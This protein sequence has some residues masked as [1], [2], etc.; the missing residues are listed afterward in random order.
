MINWCC[1]SILG[2][3]ETIIV[4][5]SL[6]LFVLELLQFVLFLGALFSPF[7]DVLLQLLIQIRLLLLLSLWTQVCITSIICTANPC[8]PCTYFDE[9]SFTTSTSRV[10]LPGSSRDYAKKSKKQL[11][12]VQRSDGNKGN[13]FLV[14][15][16]PIRS[17]GKCKEGPHRHVDGALYSGMQQR[18][19][20]RMEKTPQKFQFRSKVKLPI[21]HPNNILWKLTGRSSNGTTLK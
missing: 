16:I 14:N 10:L 3:L 15:W 2:K 21:R 6:G 5:L 7:Q 18:E 20:D 9:L 19:T 1:D 4:Y 13:T 12:P 17:E 8:I 11:H